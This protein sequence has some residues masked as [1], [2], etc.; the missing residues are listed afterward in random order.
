MSLAFVL[1]R[2][3]LDVN[4]RYVIAHQ[5]CRIRIRCARFPCG[6]VKQFLPQDLYV[7]LRYCVKFMLINCVMIDEHDMLKCFI[8][9]QL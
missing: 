7:M 9:Y 6:N 8:V 1:C 2:V 4:P 3:Y 5:I